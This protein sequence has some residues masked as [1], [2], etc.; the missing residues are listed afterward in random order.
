METGSC[1]YPLAYAQFPY[2]VAS[3]SSCSINPSFLHTYYPN[4]FPVVLSASW[5]VFF[6]ISY[7]HNSSPFPSQLV[8]WMA[9]LLPLFTFSYFLLLL[10]CPDLI[11]SPCTSNKNSQAGKFPCNVCHVHIY[12][13]FSLRHLLPRQDIELEELACL[14]QHGHCYTWLLWRVKAL[15]YLSLS[16]LSS[17]AVE[18]ISTQS[19][20]NGTWDTRHKSRSHAR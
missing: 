18:G 17:A 2:S 15:S 14:I 7:F 9:F 4:Q 16:L 20:L 3:F 19:T 11:L 5:T 1:Y 10:L 12:T 6:I 13:Y 8:C